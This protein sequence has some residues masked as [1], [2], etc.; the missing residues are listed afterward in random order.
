MQN[1]I[2]SFLGLARKAGKLIYG[3]DTVIES[4]VTEKAKLII[5]SSDASE[6]LKNEIKHAAT[7]GEKNIMVIESEFLMEEFALSL[8]KKAAVFSITDQSF[9]EKIKSMFG[10][11]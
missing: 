5:L 11:A 8:G 1:K 2:L 7:Y 10:E 4:I 6:R 9:A 3:H